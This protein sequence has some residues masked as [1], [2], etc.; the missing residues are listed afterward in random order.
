MSW[1]FMQFLFAFNLMLLVHAM[2]QSGIYECLLYNISVYRIKDSH[3]T[4]PFMLLMIVLNLLERFHTKDYN[5]AKRYMFV[6][7]ACRLH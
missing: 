4:T 1:I 6:D 2:D 7:S 3:R 5:K